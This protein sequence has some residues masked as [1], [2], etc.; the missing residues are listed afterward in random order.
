MLATIFLLIRKDGDKARPGRIIDSFL[1]TGI[2]LTAAF[3]GVC[4]W[5]M[6]SRIFLV[7]AGSALNYVFF[8]QVLLLAGL[9]LANFLFT[10]L[11][12]WVTKDEDRESWP[13][14]F[15]DWF[16]RTGAIV[17]TAAFA[18]FCLWAM[19]TRLFLV[20]SGRE[21]EL[22]R[23]CEAILIPSLQEMRLSAGTQVEKILEVPVPPTARPTATATAT[24][25]TPLPLK[26]EY[27]FKTGWKATQIPT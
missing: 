22:K 25:T 20:P 9:L 26:N 2:V 15:L 1:R 23:E 21:F 19:A 12:S 6:A 7:P 4:L 14:S 3:A 8:A 17:L 11:A 24:P 27:T 13:R 10:G 18:G 16:L 5:A